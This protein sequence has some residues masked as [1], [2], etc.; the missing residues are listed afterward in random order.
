MQHFTVKTIFGYSAL[1][2]AVCLGSGQALAASATSAPSSQQSSQQRFDIAAQPV[3]LQTVVAE[4]DIDV[5]LRRQQR[6]SRRRSITADPDRQ[7]AASG[8]QDRLIAHFSRRGGWGNGARCRIFSAVAATDD[9]GP[10]A[11]YR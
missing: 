5:G 9:A 6:L 1:A 10:P 8:E 7:P 4:N 11:P 3:V 2:L